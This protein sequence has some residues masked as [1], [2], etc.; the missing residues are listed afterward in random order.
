MIISTLGEDWEYEGEV[1][2]AGSPYGFGV[3]T[4]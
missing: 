3:A 4:S 1:D 2:E